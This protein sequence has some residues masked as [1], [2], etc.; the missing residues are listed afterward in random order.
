MPKLRVPFEYGADRKPLPVPNGKPLIV[1]LVLAVEC[2]RFDLPMSRRILSVRDPAHAP[3]IPNFSWTEYA[4]RSGMPRLMKI[5]EERGLKPD[6]CINSALID[7]Y[8]RVAEVLLRADCE[9]QGHGVWQEPLTIENENEVIAEA[10][11]RIKAF[12]GRQPRG[13]LGPGLRETFNTPDVLK[14]NGYDYVGD[15]ALDDVPCW[16][17]TA[18]GP[19][20]V[21][22][23]TVE[24]NDYVV[25]A[26]ENHL[27]DEQYNRVVHTLEAFDRELEAEPR[28]LTIPFHHHLVGVPHRAPFVAKILDLLLERDDVQFLSGSEICDWFTQIDQSTDSDTP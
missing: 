8:P 25:F 5:F 7:E 19:L 3:D 9:F 10:T 11:G 1:N 22:P 28:V 17:P 13:W 16:M 14:A 20:V 12:T 21:H 15:W 6:T 27:S 18:H 24:L 4:M 26:V 2:F 23:Y